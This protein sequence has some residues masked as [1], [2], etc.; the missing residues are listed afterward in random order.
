M[1]S[2]QE[3]ER[4]ILQLPKPELRVLRVWFDELEAAVWD[5]EFEIEKEPDNRLSLTFG[6]RG[7][8]SVAHVKPVT[9]PPEGN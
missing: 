7:G 5:Q 2:I 6:G 4:A 1:N 9:A 3:I 8:T